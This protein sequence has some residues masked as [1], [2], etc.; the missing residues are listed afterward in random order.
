MRRLIAALA[1]VVLLALGL[2]L[3]WRVYVHHVET[4]P[5]DSILSL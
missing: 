4:E 5:Y 1:I 3:L 2:T